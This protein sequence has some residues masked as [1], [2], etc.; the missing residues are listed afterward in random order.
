MD[1]RYGLEAIESASKKHLVLP[2]KASTLLDPADLVRRA[3]D[4]AIARGFRVQVFATIAG[5]PLVALTRR[6]VG[7]RP[8]IYLSAGIHGDEPAACE[9][10]VR[11]LEAGHFDDRATWFIVPMLNPTG[12]TRAQRENADGLDLNRDYRHLQS[13]EIRGHVAWL[14]AQP[15]FDLT[16]CLHED[17]EAAGFYLYELNPALRPSLA[18]SLLDAAQQHLPIDVGAMIDGRAVAAPG[19]IRPEADPRLREL[20]PEAIYLRA[21]HTELSYTLET[22]SAFPLSQRVD[23]YVAIVAAG[24]AT[25]LSST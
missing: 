10:L 7:P 18:P 9:A 12:F 2:V 16:L 4:A 21:H 24:L 8:R 1:E 15:R 25:F 19:I 14:Q 3:A 6:V 23:A 22:P 13:A 11:L 5:C 20:W 17:W